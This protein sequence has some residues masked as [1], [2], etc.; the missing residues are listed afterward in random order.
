MWDALGNDP[1]RLITALDELLLHGTMSGEMRPIIREAVASIPADDRR[2]RVQT[3]IYLIA[4][5]PQYQV[6][7]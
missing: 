1:D 3:A 5:S 2:L 7:R 6:Q 4:T